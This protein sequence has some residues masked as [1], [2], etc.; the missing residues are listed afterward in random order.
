[1]HMC[2]KLTFICKNIGGIKHNKH[3]WYIEQQE[4]ISMPPGGILEVSWL[5]EF[6]DFGT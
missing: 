2:R 1:M 6:E 5:F 4:S 3:N